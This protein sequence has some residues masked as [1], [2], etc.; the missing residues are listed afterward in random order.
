[1]LAAVAGLPPDEIVDLIREAVSEQLLVSDGGGYRLRHALLREALHAD[2]L[3]AE[4]VGV[5]ASYARALSSTP[6]L[7]TAGR[8]AAAAELADHWKEADEA[9]RA[10]N[11]WVEAGEAAEE[12]LAFAEARHHFEHAL[13]VW[14][15]VVDAEDR[16]GMPQLELLRHAAED[17]FLGGDPDGAAA[18]GHR[19]I[20]LIDP[21]AEPMLAGMLH[22]RLAR[23]LWD[24]KDQ[25]DALA[26]Q[27][28]AVELVPADPPTAER[29]HVLASLG[30]HLMVL[31][32]Y[33]EAR[34]TS[35]EAIV[36]AREVGTPEPEYVALNTLGTIVCTT[37]D[38]DAGLRLVA[39]AFRM[40][41][42]NGD[43]LEQMRGYW[44]LFANS[45]TAARWEDAL[46]RFHEAADA[47]PRLGQAHLI[48]E[49]QVTAADC[50]L[51]L[52]R[53]DE[54]EAMV[55]Q[56]RLWQRP[57]ED[58]IR[59]PDLDIARGRFAE[60]RDYLERKGVEQ[61]VINK[62][63][64]GWPR[65]HLAEIAV[66]EGRPDAARDLV[67]EGLGIT[68]DQDE[69][70]ATAYLCAIGLRAEADRADEARARRRPDDR[71]EAL[72]VG[73]RLL[74]LVRGVLARPGPADGWK[75]EVGALGA[76]CEA[77]AA[78][79][80]A[81]PDATA[82]WAH[83][84]Q[85]WE[86][87]S[88]PYAAAYCRWRQAEALL[89]SASSRDRARSTLQAAHDT[90]AALGAAPLLEAILRLARR[91]RID[92]G[93]GGRPLELA[94]EPALTRREHDVLELVAAGRSNQQIAE[95]LYISHK[96]ASVHVSNILRK[97]QV[98]SRGEA[99]AVAYR[100]GLV[101]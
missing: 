46:L 6:G 2:L 43:A 78:R 53:W 40:A 83:A 29:A 90:A 98:A 51:R 35:E 73:S 60:A 16:A 67:D 88:M 9:P 44:N 54:A 58:P 11:A 95:A 76:Q 63:L 94:E 75:R 28:R 85:V 97:L 47:L 19:A 79:M 56:A 99:A 36:I 92:V 37:E 38:V 27:L 23:Y 24:T 68:A 30:G 77:E 66:W 80:H 87:L 31:G 5:H 55:A 86:A 25:P 20:A 50:V 91:A 32:R 81:T 21:A 1:L 12:L 4:R 17:A 93:S 96:T 26:I 14:D 57:G 71:A 100:R 101:G 8:A 15:R 33:Q 13:D 18:L 61:P 52:G 72:V 64:E 49:L 45:F 69:S 84:V 48:P 10:L 3:P 74:E 7:A 65:I 59:L 62:E 70:L 39:E 22:D 89:G 82:R 41:Q 34:R 42:A